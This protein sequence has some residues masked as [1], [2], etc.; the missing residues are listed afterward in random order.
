MRQIKATLSIIICACMLGVAPGFDCSLA[1]A[2][3]AQ[4]QVE[5]VPAN[6]GMG[7]VGAS[8]I[9]AGGVTAGPTIG[10]SGAALSGTFNVN[11]PVLQ[12]QPQVLAAPLQALAPV[13]AQAPVV[14]PVDH[15]DSVAVPVVSPGI[16]PNMVAPAVIQADLSQTEQVKTKGGFGGRVMS[17]LQKMLRSFG[18]AQNA[19]APVSSDERV[20]DVIV[21]FG[22]SAK[23]ISADEHL[24]LVGGSRFHAQQ[25][26]LSHIGMAGLEAD[27]M[28][29]YNATPIA[30]YA[31]INAATIRVEAGRAAGFRQLLE[32]RGFKVYDNERRRIIEPAPSKPEDTD[33]L[34]HSAIS[35]ED[36]LKITKAD[37]VQALAQKAWGAPELGLAGRFALKL[38]GA[39]IPQPAIGVIDTGADLKHPLLKRVKALVNATSGPNVDDNGHGSWVT[40]MVLNYAPWLKNLTHYKVF[41][42]EGGATLDDILKALTMAGNDG[43]LVV[44]NSWGDD[45]GDPQ[46]PDAQLVRKLAQEGHIMVFAAGNSGPG[47]NT[48]GAPA[49]VQYKD[50]KTGAIHVVAVAA[51]DRNK[52]VAFFSSR[53]PGSP[54]TANDPNYKDHRPDLSAPG[55]NT[56]GAWPMDQADAADRVDPV[57]GPIKAI[58]GTS[59][60][61]PAVAGAIALLA[62]VFGVTSVGD[63]L[64][65]VVN[66]IMATVVKTGQSEDAEGQGFMDVEAAFREISKVLTPVVPSLAARAAVE[67]AQGS[68]TRRARLL[69]ASAI[70]EDAVWAYRALGSAPLQ[71]E[72]QYQREW[73]GSSVPQSVAKENRDRAYAQYYAEKDGLL[74]RYPELP[75]RASLLGRIQLAL[76]GGR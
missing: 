48:I 50:A 1:A 35:M 42:G 20:V 29:S 2:A 58:S 8:L 46:G 62:Q 52:K 51:T 43:N 33:P 6:V 44:S 39:A 22:Q 31:R 45:Q 76:G 56:E 64:D 4:T 66:G 72:A 37:S 49:I 3:V 34:F 14:T 26:M 55:Y 63:Q 60:S 32:S 17:Q 18:Q 21:M 11:S 25:R 7:A 9:N 24:S 13:S 57:F 12:I 61:T 75:L 36:N 73:L 15:P 38:S 47:A 59:M 68:Q 5:A 65:A 28:A 74:R 23:P 40:S 69:A 53:G 71:I 10:L 67:F 30:T 16:S 54:K 41:T 27:A 70:P 19:S